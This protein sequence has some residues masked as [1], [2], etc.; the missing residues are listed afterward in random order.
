MIVNFEANKLFSRNNLKKGLFHCLPM[1]RPEKP[2]VP[3]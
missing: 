2:N 1:I 3:L